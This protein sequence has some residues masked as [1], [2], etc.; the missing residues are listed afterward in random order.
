MRILISGASGLI[1]SALRASL[2]AD[3]HTTVALTR[4]PTSDD[5][6]GWN[7]STGE[8][9]TRRL[10]GFDAIVNLA[11]ESISGHW[12]NR[13]KSEIRASR[14][15]GTTI[16]ADAIAAQNSP[17]GVLVNSSAT[18][19]YGDRGDEM[20]D[21]STP[22]G[23]DFLAQVSQE[24]E[25]AALRARSDST[26]VVLA[27]TGIVL[28]M[29][30]GALAKLATPLRLGVAGPLGSGRQWWSWISLRDEVRAIRHLINTDGL[31]GPVNL[32]SDADRNADIIR[33]A[34][35]VV[36]RPT[37]LRAP[38]FGLRLLLGEM[39]DA[40]LLASTRVAATKLEQSGFSFEDPELEP[41][42]E[43]LFGE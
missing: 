32:V 40:L 6:I 16:I 42:L 13:K 29:E 15:G 34:G 2:N 24:W 28:S 27:R 22:A 21:E 20:C 39:A 35:R 4:R 5:D 38:S 14:V 23:S 18:G 30:D 36:G 41:A 10:E 12:T 11:G 33:T 43:R 25:E 26:R 17:P 7:P 9:D 1:G 31:E 19:I 37:I 3:G 8:I